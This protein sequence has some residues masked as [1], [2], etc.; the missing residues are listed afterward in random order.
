MLLWTP[1][2]E[3]FLWISLKHS[4][5]IYENTLHKSMKTSCIPK[6]HCGKPKTRSEHFRKHAE[7][8]P[9]TR[10]AAGT[11]KNVTDTLQTRCSYPSY[12][13]RVPSRLPALTS[14]HAAGVSAKHLRVSQSTRGPLQ[15]RFG[16]LKMLC[17]RS[18]KTCS[19]YQSKRK[20]MQKCT[21]RSKKTFFDHTWRSVPP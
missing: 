3:F 20:K 10:C 15:T 21:R 17:F 9:E 4:T 16:T 18:F 7:K 13:L 12:P 11:S 5:G 14:K 6:I 19:G 2:P 8:I 1:T